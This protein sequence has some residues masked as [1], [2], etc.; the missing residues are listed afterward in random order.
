[1]RI[2]KGSTR[3]VFIFNKLVIK[4]P[5]LLVQYDH[6]LYGLLANINE[7][8][9]SGKH[10]DLAKVFYGNKFGFILIMEKAEVISNDINWDKFKDSLFKIYQND[11][12][13]EFML[14]DYKPSNW[15][16]IQNRLV[17]IDYGKIG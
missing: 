10:K 1:M 9:M 12:L 11:E 5:N 6:F 4:M 17:K 16:Y 2:E 14:S 8:K 3:I 13:R 15:G 7:R